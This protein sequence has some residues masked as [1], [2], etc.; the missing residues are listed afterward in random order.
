MI[1]IYERFR[2]WLRQSVKTKFLFWNIGFWIVAVIILSLT[3]LWTSQ[4]EILSDIRNRNIQIASIISRDINARIS[5]ILSDARMFAGYFETVGTD[6]TNQASTL[7]KLRISAP[8]RYQAVYL[9]NSNNNILLHLGDPYEDLVNLDDITQITSRPVTPLDEDIFAASREVNE[10]GI[11]ISEANST[12]LDQTPVIYVGLPLDYP[13][14]TSQVLV[15]QVDIRDIRQRI[16]LTTVGNSGFTYAVSGTGTIIAHPD[17]AF[18]GSE[19]APELS[20]VLEGYEGFEEYYDPVKQRSVYSAYSPIGSPTNWGIIVEQDKFEAN[21]PIVR[22]TIIVIIVGLSLATIGTI[23]ILLMIQNFTRPVEE[24]TRTTQEIQRTGE[25]KKTS[26]EERPDE[27]GQ[28]SQ[29]FDG[30]IDRLK[31]M[32]GR[33]EMAA[34]EERNRLARDLHDAVSQTLFSASIIA[35][36]LPALWE[37]DNNKGRERLEEVRQLT[38]GALAEMRTLLLELRPSALLEV[39]LPLLLSQLADSISGRARIPIRFSAEGECDIPDEVKV[40]LYRIAQEALNNVAKHSGADKVQVNLVCDRDRVIMEIIDNGTGF[41]IEKVSHEHLGVG[42]MQERAEDIEASLTVHS[43][44]GK[45][46]EVTVIWENY[47]PEE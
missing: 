43:E 10:S 38:R 28:L 29:S 12:G 6:I 9:L 23:G 2:N 47:G 7:V 13:D 36:V 4:S 11:Y 30:M 35:E 41:N 15:L 31:Q 5:N 21:A 8:Q 40:A 33:L 22:T 18:L 24:L 44:E 26:L 37:K 42:I 3:F 32:E 25:L 46:T 19:L 14:G 34:A 20:G 17:P 27:I 45:G 16:N 39:E 1:D